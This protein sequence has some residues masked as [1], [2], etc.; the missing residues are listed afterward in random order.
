MSLDA[1]YDPQNIFARIIAGDMPCVKLHEDEATLAFMDVFPQ[2]EGHCLI[3]HKTAPAT[4]ILTIAPQALGAVMNSVQKITTAVVKGLSPDGVR[5]AQFNGAPAG[6]TVF[7]LHFH[8]IPV[9]EGTVLRPHAGGRPAEASLLEPVA[10]KIR[11][12]L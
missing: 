12:A 4:N 8:V 7:H 10:A 5:V 9:Y 6:Q 11:A 2:S 1:P 3:V